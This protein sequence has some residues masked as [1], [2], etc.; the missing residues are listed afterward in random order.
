MAD[1]VARTDLFIGGEWRPAESGER[2]DVV[3]PGTEE[4][5][6][7]VANAGAADAPRRGR[8]GGRRPA[9][10]GRHRRRGSGPRCC[11]ARGSCSPSGPT[12]WRA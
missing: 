11:V 2:F 12:T 7:T 10:V 9:R 3:D 4:V 6:A 5:I 1:D 8:R